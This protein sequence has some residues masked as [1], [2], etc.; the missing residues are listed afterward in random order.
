MS[1]DELLRRSFVSL[2]VNA[3]FTEATLVLSD[4]SRLCFRHRVG[5]RWVRAEGSDDA[6]AGQIL[7][8]VSQF[9]L[10]AKHLQLFFE[11]GTDAE[12]S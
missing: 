7:A 10:N 1:G 2:E 6:L 5:Q 9:R 11:D 12:F 4:G 3:D 8:G